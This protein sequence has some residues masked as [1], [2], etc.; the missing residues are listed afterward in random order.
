MGSTAN[1][2]L[3][4][5]RGRKGRC[6]FPGPW[7]L[8]TGRE[9]GVWWNMRLPNVFTPDFHEVWPAEVEAEGQNRS[10][11]QAELGWR[12]NSLLAP[13]SWAHFHQGTVASLPFVVSPDT[14]AD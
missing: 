7:I 5:G 12:R 14:V 1:P 10:E 6:L 2:D 9:G 4:A 13:H 3:G 8:A 11:R